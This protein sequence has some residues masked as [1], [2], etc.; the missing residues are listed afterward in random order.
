[1]KKLYLYISF[2]L[3]LFFFNEAKA[4]TLTGDMVVCTTTTG[5]IVNH[6]QFVAGDDSGDRDTTV[7]RQCDTTGS[8][9]RTTLTL[10]KIGLCT[11]AP[12]VKFVDTTAKTNDQ[13]EDD[14][15]VGDS[16][17]TSCQFVVD[18]TE[19]Y[20]IAM[21]SAG[22]VFPVGTDEIVNPG[23][24]TH[25][26]FVID[27]S[28]TVTAEV[29]FSG[30]ITSKNSG[31][32]ANTGQSTRCITNGSSIIDTGAEGPIVNNVV[33]GG[34][35]ALCHSST[36]ATANTIRYLYMNVDGVGNT[37]RGI[38]STSLGSINFYNVNDNLQRVRILTASNGTGTATTKLLLV[39]TFTNPLVV[40]QNYEYLDVLQN[41]SRTVSLDFEQGNDDAST[42]IRLIQQGPFGIAFRTV[43]GTGKF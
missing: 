35:G 7:Y 32:S 5:N 42:T 12:T 19:G 36:A 39:V 40:T 37:T 26:V 22:E 2:I 14:G 4:Q 15:D 23:T 41:L 31:R 38:E 3:S 27:E 9:V 13:R 43:E 29:N 21:S 20:L 34:D 30:T 25:G 17:F 11:S 33:Y 18:S 16:I 8:S 10:H 6:T 1:M 28:V 24:Y